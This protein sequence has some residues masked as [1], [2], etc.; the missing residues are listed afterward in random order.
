MAVPLKFGSEV[1]V[2]TTTAGNQ[3][4]ASVQALANGQYFVIWES[5][6]GS[7][8]EIRARLFNAD[9]TTSLTEFQVNQVSDGPQTLPSMTLLEDGRVLAVWTSFFNFS[10]EVRGRILNEIGRAHV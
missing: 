10:S 7:S 9:G 5:D 6:I 4:N 2:N 1:L 8:T 3:T